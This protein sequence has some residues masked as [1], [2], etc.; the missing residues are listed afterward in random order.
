MLINDIYITNPPRFKDP[1]STEGR[2]S[3]RAREKHC[4]L[5]WQDF[6]AH[7]FIAAVVAQT[8]PEQVQAVTISAW[9]RKTSAAPPL[10]EELLTANGCWSREAHLLQ[11]CGPC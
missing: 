10:T 3:V 4:L 11:G 8:R 1:L 6:Y 5:T 9:S 7:E 2:K